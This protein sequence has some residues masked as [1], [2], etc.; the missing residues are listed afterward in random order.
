[1]EK[2]FSLGS[3]RLDGC[4]VFLR[5]YSRH[6]S[7][8]GSLLDVPTHTV[9]M[10]TVRSQDDLWESYSINIHEVRNELILSLDEAFVNSNRR[11][12][13]AN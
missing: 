4:H 8:V 7:A 11:K 9:N 13:G 5:I 6:L 2:V 10:V 3:V 1:M 12:T